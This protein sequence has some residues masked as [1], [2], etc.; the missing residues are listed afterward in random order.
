VRLWSLAPWLLDGKG[1]VAAWREGLL[2][3]A[4]LLGLTRGY[5]HHP[6]LLRFRQAQEPVSALDAYLWEVAQE[7]AQRGYRFASS[8]LGQR[9]EVPPL[10]V[11]T[12][13]LDWEWGHLLAKLVRRD[14]SWWE[15]LRQEP[16]PQPHPL[17]RLVP[18]PVEPWE[19]AAHKP[20]GSQ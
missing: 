19:R 16:G 6:Q 13:Q 14:L 15:R 4:V 18:G 20:K 12:G 17:F 7:G 9:K 1:L 8:K 2:A 11:T 10:T 3:R 5:Q